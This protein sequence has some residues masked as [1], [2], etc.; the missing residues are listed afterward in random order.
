[1]DQLVCE[2]RMQDEMKVRTLKCREENL[3]IKTRNGHFVN[4]KRG[5][6]FIMLDSRE[7]IEE[8]IVEIGLILSIVRF[9]LF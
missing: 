6:F 2:R 8:R 7:I 1:M 5:I 3:L 4:S 9:L